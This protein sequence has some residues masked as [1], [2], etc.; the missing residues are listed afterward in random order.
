VSDS[1]AIGV[2]MVGLSARG[3]W[4]ARAHVPALRAVPGYELRAV[5][6]SSP[7]SAAEAAR[8]FDVPIA[9]GS[10][11]E[12]AAR[13]EVDLVVVCVKVPHHRELVLAAVEAG[14][15]VLCEWPLGN[16]LAEA[17]ELAAAAA[18]RVRGFVGLQGRSAPATRY[19]RSL[20][21]DGA[22]GEILSTTLVGSGGNWGETIPGAGSVYLLDRAN[23]AHMLTIPAGHSVDV[24]CTCL[25]EFAEV[26]ATV[27]TRRRSVRRV[28]TGESVPMSAFDQVAVT[29]TLEGGAVATVHYR[30]GTS[31]ALPLYWEINGTEGELVVTAEEGHLQRARFHLRKDGVELPIPASLEL[32]PGEPG[33]APYNVA[34]AYAQ[35]SG[36]LREGTHNVPTFADA[37]VRHRLIDAVE[38]SGASG[39]RQVLER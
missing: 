6:G 23:G 32:V 34:Q 5:S 27:A 9:C 22:L 7:E 12:L 25:G 10:V 4:A 36:D 38:R 29:G 31:S 35:L 15:D 24:L 17:E 3:G 2:G 30:G 11:E 21:E 37:V 28:D 33:S 8:E 14:K 39:E 26:S 1:G 19:V 13:P 20:V 16:G 18:G